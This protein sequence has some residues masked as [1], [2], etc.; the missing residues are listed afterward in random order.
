[1]YPVLQIELVLSLAIKVLR[2]T[3]KEYVFRALD[4]RECL[5]I[6]FPTSH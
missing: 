5:M 6:I 3:E 4:K 2:M 1:M